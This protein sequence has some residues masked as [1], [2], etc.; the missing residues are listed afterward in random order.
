MYTYAYLA[1][2]LMLLILFWVP[3]YLRLG[4][5]DRSV[6]LLLSALSAPLGPITVLFFWHDYW[7]PLYAFPA[8]AGLEEF[9]FSFL[10]GG[11]GGGAYQALVGGTVPVLELRQKRL[12]A[13]GLAGV[14]LTLFYYGTFVLGINSLYTSL[15]I[16]GLLAACELAYAKH[17][18]PRAVVGALCTAGAMFIMYQIWFLI[19][20]DAL[21]FW[22]TPALS[23]IYVLSVPLE[24]LLWGALWGAFAGP[25]YV[26]VATS[27]YIRE[28]RV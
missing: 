6:M 26:F 17:L 12:W 23:G 9:I 15:V 1:G 13:F 28:Y 7:S 21:S 25:A 3:L 24:E 10:I 27:R 22:N 8:L 19:F 2:C 5:R 14:S 4:T 18:W 20:P 16:L 11:I